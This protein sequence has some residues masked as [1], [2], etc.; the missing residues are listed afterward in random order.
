MPSLQ[1]NTLLR[2]ALKRLPENRGFTLLEL[3]VA[4]SIFAVVSALAFGGMSQ[5]LTQRVLTEEKADKLQQL[6][7]TYTILERDFSQLVNRPVR[8]AYGNSLSALAGSGGI[9]GVELTRSG[10]ANPAGF[11][12]SGLQRVRYISEDEQLLR[13][14]WKVLDRSPDSEAA[15]Q[16]LYEPVESFSLR[17]LDQADQWR[18]TWPPV[19][20]TPGAAPG[21]PRAV[22]VVIETEDFGEI[23][24]LFR[25]PE[26]FTPSPKAPTGGS[27]STG[28]PASGGGATPGGSSTNDD[29]EEFDDEDP[30]DD[31]EDP[32]PG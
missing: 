30:D 1:E 32:A 16:V 22:E 11:R 19:G 7:I 15:Q 8:N 3:L 6:Q 13:Q 14:A 27:A 25:S 18:E 20:G 28:N 29:S 26:P 17:Y 24:W 2:Q 12:R 21:L 9:E 31:F 23:T 4:L 10:F 5:V